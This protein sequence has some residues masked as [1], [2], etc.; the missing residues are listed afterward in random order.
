MGG[1]IFERSLALPVSADEAFKWHE[2]PGALE[3]LIPPWESV[4]VA[5]RGQ[6]VRDGS[7]VKLVA[8]FG[9]AKLPWHAEHHGYIA[10]NR[11]R[12]TQR[13]GPFA[14]WEH[15]HEFLSD[16]RG[17]GTLRD[18]VE[19]CLPGGWLGALCGGRVV[20]SKIER[21]F[22][23][24]HHTTYADLAAHS[25]YQGAGSMHV[26]VTGASG[27]VGSTL[28]P[29]L[30]T[31]GHSVTRLVRRNAREGDVTWDPQADS[32][33]ASPLEGVDAVVHLAGENIGKSRWNAKLK[34]RMRDSRVHATRVLC[35]GFAKMPTRPK[36]LVCASAIGFYGDRG[37]EMLSEESMPGT[38]YL[39][40]LV[41]DW[42][43]ATTP[44]AEA[45]IRVVNLRFGVILSPKDG[46]L[47]KMLLPFKL[48]V[49]GR[50]GSGKQYWS[51]VSIDD[52]AGIIL[53]AIMREGICGPVNAVAPN[54]VT[55]IEFTK[56]LGHVLR[57]PTIFPMPAFA[58]R[59]ALGEMADELLLASSRV[60][61][62]HLLDSGY[63]FRQ[64]TLEVALRHLLGR[65]R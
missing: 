53:H 65:T 18:R 9:P 38:G 58:A 12:D 61:A 23:Y 19:Y 1:M 3:R 47:A 46:A 25:K 35:E 62:G 43:A 44:A 5:Q 63:D 27:L 39:A 31:G 54:P 37:D 36:V 28:C 56:T 32:F 7:V 50:V 45:G 17:L 40:E 55:N 8:K 24:R 30:T 20:R 41:K 48:C 26:A 10:G 34:Q 13:E 51:W 6:G 11:F 64:P 42:E 57:R 15:L 22:E 16:E 29:L 4:R 59:L 60:D 21:M 14:V 2:R 33:D 52:A 49:G